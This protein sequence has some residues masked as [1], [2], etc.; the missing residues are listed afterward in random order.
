MTTSHI[1]VLR[2]LAKSSPTAEVVFTAFALRERNRSEPVR[3]GRFKSR[4]VELGEAIDDKAYKALFQQLAD[5]GLGKVF[6]SKAGM[7]FKPSRSLKHLGA[8]AL[9]DQSVIKDM[10]AK[11]IRAKT[12]RKAA[13]MPLVDVPPVPAAA[14]AAIL[15]PKPKPAISRTV[16]VYVIKGQQFKFE[17][18]GDITAEQLKTLS[19]MFQT[20]NEEGSRKAL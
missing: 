16:V 9:N 7:S 6:R 17:L 5:A 12:L 8:L 18:P 13:R 10:E 4:L 3:L 11:L 14:I 2:S 20:M 1:E 15:N 19:D